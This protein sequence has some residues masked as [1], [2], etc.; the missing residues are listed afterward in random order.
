MANV[1]T[2][3]GSIDSRD[4]GVTLMHEHLLLDAR[5]SWQ[6]PKEAS[7]IALARRPV[8]PNILHELRQDPFMNLDNCTLLDEQAAAEE[9]EQ[10]KLLGGATVVD[11]TCRGIG[12]DPLALQRISQ[13]T[14]LNIVMGTGY[15][16]EDR[17]PPYVRRASI[18]ELKDEMVIDL[19]EG[20]DG[21]GIRAGYLGEIGI[22]RGMTSQEEKALRAA[23]RAQV[24][25]GVALSI[26]LPGW[27]RLGHRV[28]DVIEQEGG[29]PSR[30][31]LD[32][33]NPSFA[34][35]DYQRELAGRGAYLEYDM[36]GM[37]YYFAN[38]DTQCPSDD[39]NARAIAGLI[40]AGYVEHLLLSQDVFLKMMLTR[41]GGN[42]YAYISRHFLPRLRRHGVEEQAL[43]TM[44]VTNPARVL[45]GTS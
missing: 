13:L 35:S 37:D 28:I 29:D 22:G 4:L 18:D 43:E 34:D 27:E 32:H 16:L 17:H 7:R 6:E 25:T 21:T 44:M 20:V 39:D 45:G 19:L 26:H 2:V 14:G 33:M 9:V 38:Q 23:A 11:A 31:V 5:K 30:T 10:F 1:Q 36:I 15:Y 3:R 42:G 12:R 41:Y 40:D 8:T 24:R